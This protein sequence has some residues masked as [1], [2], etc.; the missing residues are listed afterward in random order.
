MRLVGV[1]I[2]K[3][4]GLTKRDDDGCDPQK[5]RDRGEGRAERPRGRIADAED[6]R[7]RQAEA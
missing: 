5:D 7:S 4:A 6:Q 2:R 3:V 1:D